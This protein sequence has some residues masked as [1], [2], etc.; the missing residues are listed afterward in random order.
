[1]SMKVTVRA[2]WKV[3][4]PLCATKDLFKLEMW[5]PGGG[6]SIPSCWLNAS[7]TFFGSL[8]KVAALNFNSCLDILVLGKLFLRYVL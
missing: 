4:L 5:E 1:M 8:L 7:T 6:P 3:Q 2:W